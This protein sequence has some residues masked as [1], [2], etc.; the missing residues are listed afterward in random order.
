MDCRVKPGNGGEPLISRGTIDADIRRPDGYINRARPVR[1]F[2]VVL[3]V[4][5]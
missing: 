4:W 5:E 3:D 1:A 2:G